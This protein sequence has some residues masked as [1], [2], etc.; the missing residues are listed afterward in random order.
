M[1]NQVLDVP[2]E[3]IELEK[4]PDRELLEYI[5]ENMITAEK[6]MAAILENLPK[7]LQ[8]L[9]DSPTARMILRF[10]S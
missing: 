6:I 10:M 4:L 1:S 3:T 2:H 5:A 8:Q 7:A 9:D